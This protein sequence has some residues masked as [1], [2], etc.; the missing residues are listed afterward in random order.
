MYYVHICVYLDKAELFSMNADNC[1]E[2]AASPPHSSMG[3]Y[4]IT[5]RV[6]TSTRDGTG[7]RGSS[8]GASRGWE[9]GNN[10][11]YQPTGIVEQ[12]RDVNTELLKTRACEQGRERERE[13]EREI[14]W[15]HPQKNCMQRSN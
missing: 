4:M 1:G 15:Q 3:G 12:L 2:L 11:K 14:P 8:R 10:V 9:R 13:R 5:G 6:G 7:V